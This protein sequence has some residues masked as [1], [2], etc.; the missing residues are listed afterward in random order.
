MY[1]T[2]ESFLFLFDSPG[3]SHCFKPLFY[4]H[5]GQKRD[6][7]EP[8]ILLKSSNLIVS[9]LLRVDLILLYYSFYFHFNS[10]SIFLFLEL[11]VRIRVT[12]THCHTSVTSDDMVIVM[13]INHIIHRRT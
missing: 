11:R 8:M 3:K 12:R 7:S 6:L 1:I 5:I 13:V 2:V 9:R 4:L 10:F